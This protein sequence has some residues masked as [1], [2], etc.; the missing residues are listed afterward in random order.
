LDSWLLAH[1]VPQLVFLAAHREVQAE[2]HGGF[3]SHTK[4]RG[5]LRRTS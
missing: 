2:G 1:N 3:A 4:V 5:L